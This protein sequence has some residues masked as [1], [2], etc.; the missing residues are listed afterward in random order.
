M[1]KLTT[2][3]SFLG[4]LCLVVPCYG[5]VQNEE[6]P[7]QVVKQFYQHL[8][9]RRYVEGFRLSVYSAAIEGL[10]AEEMRT[11]EPEFRRI[12]A[13]LP[14]EI[15]TRG[16]QISGDQA[17][18]FIK[19][20]NE[21]QMQQVTLIRI[22]GQWRVGDYETYRMTLRQGRAFFFNAR[23][24]VAEAE[25]YEWLQEIIGAEA[26]Y[27]RARQRFATLEELINL[28]GVSK[29]L[30]NGS[31]SGYRF[32]LAIGEDGK[33]FRL[34]AVPAEYGRT[35]RLSFYV[36]HSYVIRAEDREGQP[37]TALS[38]QYQPHTP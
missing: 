35:G 31:E 37:A 10:S 3:G 23:I 22:D 21:R 32:R 15:E 1:S 26:I 6:S 20:P 30:I 34:I 28:G 9:A 24:Q 8:H 2:V 18:V 29:Q 13:Q 19:L 11:L 4:M 38:P 14:Q 12:A 25:A 7:S 16:E 5:L 17:T 27:F 36:D 33:S